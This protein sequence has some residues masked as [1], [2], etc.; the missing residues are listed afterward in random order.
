MTK[1]RTIICALV[2]AF[3]LSFA[4][5]AFAL[6]S[7]IAALQKVIM[8]NGDQAAKAV[9][10]IRVFRKGNEEPVYE[11]IPTQPML[12]MQNIAPGYM[13]RPYGPCSGVCIDKDG[14]ILTSYFNISGNVDRITVTFS[15]G[16][17]YPAKLLGRSRDLDVALLKIDGGPGNFPALTLTDKP[18]KVGSFVMTIGR[19]ENV[20]QHTLNFGLMT[21]TG[22]H[23]PEIQAWQFD[24]RVNYGNTGGAL[25]DIEGNLLGVI[26]YC[27]PNSPATPNGLGQSSGVG[28]ANTCVKLLGMMDDLKAGKVI[29]LPSRAFIGIQMDPAYLKNDGALINEVLKGTAAEEAG[30]LTGD[31]VTEVDGQAIANPSQVI[32]ILKTKKIG[33]KVQLKI[34]RGDKVLTFEITLKAAP[35]GM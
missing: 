29:T 19:A 7:E 4:A 21:A 28:L 11:K 30:V 31:L 10:Q 15:D 22:R 26:A 12:Q 13:T 18:A 25:V 14:F 1:R 34:K 17:R 8:K 23:R 16:K 33:D 27:Y 24:A 5:H 3:A 35:P 32:A 6:G 2:A 20:F 9:V